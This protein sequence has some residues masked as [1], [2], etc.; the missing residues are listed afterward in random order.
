V[1]ER[2]NLG[3]KRGRERDLGS[4]ERDEFWGLRFSAK[5]R[6]EEEVAIWGKK[7]KEFC[8]N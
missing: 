8:L 6:E 3:S 2:E 7:K 4:K 5:E 1:R